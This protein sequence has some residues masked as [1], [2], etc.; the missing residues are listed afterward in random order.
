MGPASAGRG[1]HRRAKTA[2]TGIATTGDGVLV[3]SGEFDGLRIDE[4]IT[5]IIDK[6]V[7]EGV[8]GATVIYRLRDWL[9]SWQRYSGTP[10]PIVH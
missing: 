2:R 7:R 9:L 5:A 1:G 10:I 6:L 4:A 3:N 8:G